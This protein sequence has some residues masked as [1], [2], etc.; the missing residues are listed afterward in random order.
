MPKAAYAERILE[1][2]ENV[3]ITAEKGLVTVKGLKVTLTRDFS[4][5]GIYITVDEDKVMVSATFPRKWEYAMVGTIHSHIRNMI[6][7]VTEGFEYTLEIVSTH[8]PATVEVKGKQIH[9]KN[10]YGERAPRVVQIVGDQT[11]VR[12]RGEQVIVSGP[13]IE[14]VGQTA[15]SIE[16]ICR[17][18]G[19][20]RKDPTIF[21]DGVYVSEKK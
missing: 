7:G 3:T 15:A 14:D 16:Q 12:S 2:P 13:N 17:L 1:I 18:R 21:L 11:K 20:R 19:K 10:L 6:K 4:E 5:S 8:F 9:V